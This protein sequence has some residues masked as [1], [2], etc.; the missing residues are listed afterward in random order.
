MDG[1]EDGRFLADIGA[2]CH[3]EATDEACG[4]VAEDVTE[5]VG[6]HDHVE[7]IRIDDH[8]HGH[9]VNDLVLELDVAVFLAD[10]ASDF[11]EES[12]ELLEDVRLVDDGD[13][14]AAVRSGVVES[15]ATDALHGVARVDADGHG[16]H[17]VRPHPMFHLCVEAFGVLAYGDDVQTG[18]ATGDAVKRDGGA[19]VGVEIELLAHGD[20]DTAETLADGSPAGAFERQ[21]GF[22]DSFEGF[23][24]KWRA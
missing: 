16:S 20:V 23:V 24:G 8:L 14:L 5:Q 3:A 4:K 21:A 2:G 1:L 19:E 15:E 12:G 18:V 13:L 22:C 10:L 9:V 7:L 17:V 11:E 6:G